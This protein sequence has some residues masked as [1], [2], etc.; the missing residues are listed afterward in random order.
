MKHRNL[1]YL[2]LIINKKTSTILVNIYIHIIGVYKYVWYLYIISYER[3]IDTK[4]YF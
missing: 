2:L 4:L 3:Y 1:S